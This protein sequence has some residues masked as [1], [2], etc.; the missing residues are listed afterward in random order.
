M[1]YSIFKAPSMSFFSKDFYRATAQEGK[2]TGLLYLLV[3]VFISNFIS[4]AAGSLQMY[5]SL[6]SAQVKGI[7]GQIPDLSFRDS[8]MSF[9]KPNPYD[10]TFTNPNSQ[11]K[12]HIIFDTSGQSN[13]A[14]EDA[15]AVLT[16]DGIIFESQ[17]KMT[18]WRQVL[19]GNENFDLPNTKMQEFL[20]GLPIFFFVTTAFVFAPIVYLLHIFLV[21]FYSLIGLIMDRKALGFKAAMRMVCVAMTPSILLTAL[22][23]IVFM[24]PFWP[25]LT[26]PITL[27]YLFF[28]YNSLGDAKE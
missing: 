19:F 10:M 14:A 5:M 25:I 15:A 1:Q 11:E 2:G 4:A 16:A 28:G 8:K 3:I 9:N 7:I 20:Q 26:I 18:P 12:I 24:P 21:L 27:G 22:C 23:Y 13:R 17:D 6:Q